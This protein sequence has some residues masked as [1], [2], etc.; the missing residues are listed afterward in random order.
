MTMPINAYG[1]I[2]FADFSSDILKYSVLA[3]I[4]F[5]IAVSVIASQ[6]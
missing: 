1:D 5:G 4:E 3:S 2:G 6:N